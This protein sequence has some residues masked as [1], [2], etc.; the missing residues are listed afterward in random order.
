MRKFRSSAAGF[1]AI[2]VM[3]VL[4]SGCSAGVKKTS[5]SNSSEGSTL[6][7]A[8]KSVKQ[9][10]DG[11]FEAFRRED[12]GGFMDQVALNFLGSRI[13]LESQLDEQLRQVNNIEFEY[14]VN[15]IITNKNHVDIRFRWDRRWRDVDTGQATRA[16]GNTTFRFVRRSGDW[17]LQNI[18]GNQPFFN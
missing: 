1:L 13:R 14:F 10:M 6:S 9:R 17:L 8:R 15:R 3:I 16:S 5:S 4:L 11:L 12:I 2:G 7:D 18:E